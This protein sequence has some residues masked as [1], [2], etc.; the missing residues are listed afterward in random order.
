M[1]IINWIKRNK[2][3]TVLF[4]IIAIFVGNWFLTPSYQTETLSSPSIAERDAYYNEDHE[5]FGE[6]EKMAAPAMGIPMP[7]PEVAPN[8]DVSDRLVIKES[9]MSLVVDDVYKTSDD[10]I[11]YATINNGYMVT[12]SLTSPE[13][14]P[15]AQIVIRVPADKLRQTL[16]YFRGLAVKV[17]SENLTGRDVTDEYV[18]IEARLE[19]L[20]KTKSKFEEIL[21]KSVEISDILRVQ[22]EL[23]SLQSQI[24][25]LKG[26]Q[27]YFKQNAQLAKIVVYLSTDELSLPYT[28]V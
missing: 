3:T 15:F 14:A 5:N 17:S 7:Q 23:I 21:T 13:N 28:P 2:L 8:V 22:R 10:I 18:D 4:V 6:M 20:E 11:D 16:K 27:K 1:P 24:D 26:Q 19:T 25:R 9:S 12:S